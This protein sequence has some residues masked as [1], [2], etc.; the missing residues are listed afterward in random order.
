VRLLESGKTLGRQNLEALRG[1]MRAN[2]VFRWVEPGAGFISFARFNLEMSS[3]DVCRALLGDPYRTYLVPGVCY[4]PEYDKYVRIGF[5]G[6]GSERVPDGL[7]QLDRY[8]QAVAASTSA[9]ATVRV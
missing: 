3:W 4:G 1:W 8:C 9:A 2:P 6:K 7:R 5:G